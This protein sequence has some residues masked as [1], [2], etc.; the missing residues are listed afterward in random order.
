MV[1]HIGQDPIRD[2]PGL[3]IWLHLFGRYHAPYPSA[4]PGRS[5]VLYHQFG[6]P[7]NQNID[8]STFRPI[9]VSSLKFRFLPIL[10]LF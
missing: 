7:K 6:Y 2:H 10:P 1:A 8:Y 4:E 9:Y 3:D 5:S